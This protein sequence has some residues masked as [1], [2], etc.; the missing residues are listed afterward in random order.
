MPSYKIF[1]NNRLV[2]T[3][4]DVLTPVPLAGVAT[5]NGSNVITHTALTGSNI[6]YPGMS[7]RI[8]GIPLGSFIGA[9]K[10][11]TH[12]ELLCGAWD[13]ATGVYS[14]SAANA[15]A[16]SSGTISDLSGMALGYDPLCIISPTFLLGT[17][18]NELESNT[19]IVPTIIPYASGNGAAIAGTG[20]IISNSE[21][22]AV[23][24][25]YLGLGGV[26]TV[27]P[28]YGVKSDSYDTTPLKRHNG[29][30]WGLR[31]LFSTGG[32]ISHFPATPE[33][34]IHYAAP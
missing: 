21:V 32:A 14:I 17:W 3:V 1:K 19:F 34:F 30:P 12:L 15:Q 7:V 16:T 2:T 27:T 5:V 18:R 10:D 31:L 20:T 22:T 6:V 33:W 25:D 24:V 23:A 26:I 11:S 13:A 29:E 8:P 28:T 4:P 9:I